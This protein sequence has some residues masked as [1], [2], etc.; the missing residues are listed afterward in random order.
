MMSGHIPILLIL[1][2]FL[3]AIAVTLAGIF[4]RRLCLPLVLAALVLSL[5]A[6]V[7]ALAEVVHSPSGKIH[8]RV[9]GWRPPY[10]IEL[11]VDPLNAVVLVLVVAV[12]LIAAL[13]TRYTVN[14]ELAERGPHFYTLFL[15]LVTGLLG[16]T[17]TGD[18]FNLY[19]LLEIS[20]LTAYAMIALGTGRAA[21]AAFNYVIVGT[22][23]AS[24]YL[25]GVGYLYIKTGSLNMADIGRILGELDLY[26]SKSV[27][28]AFMLILIG[29]WIKMAFFPLHGWLPNAYAYAPSATNCLI[30]P[31]MTKVSVYVMIRTIYTVFTPAY[32]FVSLNWSGLIMWAAVIAIVAGS[33]FAMA[34]TNLHKL[35]GYLII[36][37]VGYMAGGVWLANVTGLTGA[38]Y[39]IVSDA[40]M[41][42]CLFLTAAIVMYKTGSAKLQA[43]A[44]MFR[45]MPL[46][47]ACFTTAALSMIGVPPT[48]GF[49]SKW[50]LIRGGIEAGHWGF[51]G[52][53]LFSS[54]VNAFIFFRIIESA[55]FGGRPRSTV[56][57][58]ERQDHEQIDEAPAGMLVP[59]ITATASLVIVGLLTGD[60]VA[61]IELFTNGTGL[62]NG[63]G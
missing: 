22:I 13:F 10:G 32:V 53:L 57:S 24:F 1:C 28:V 37:E 12:A 30:A 43:M 52:A 6:A 46:T 42:L 41:T 50:Y 33:L 45:R 51:V 47:T 2:P 27:M 25:L 40:L 39:H 34:Q 21:L 62:I 8:Y 26:S 7:A 15:L 4:A 54:L 31:L 49:F 19:V 18:A 44:G 17:V 9:G 63:A 59:L 48:C 3:A 38:V 23:G 61:F 56:H 35:L 5:A 11:V 36:A 55:F 14:K 29:V 20:S 16:M 58:D 60:I